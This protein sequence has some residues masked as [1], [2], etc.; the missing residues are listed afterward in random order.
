MNLKLAYTPGSQANPADAGLP[1][2]PRL[3]THRVPV[4]QWIEHWFPK[5]RMWV[6]FPPGTATQAHGLLLQSVALNTR[7]GG[8]TVD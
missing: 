4:V 1:A 3:T 7:A 6:Q 2:P 5:P 8:T